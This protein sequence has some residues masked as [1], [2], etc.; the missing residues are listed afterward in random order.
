MPINLI[1]WTALLGAAAIAIGAFGAHG[2]KQLLPETSLS[3]F[4]TGVKY[5]MYHVLALLGT[6]CLYQFRPDPWLLYACRLF[7][8]GIFLFSGSLYLITLLKWNPVIGV[9][10]LGLVTPVGGVFFIA[11]WLCIW[12]GAMARK[13]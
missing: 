11:G 3:A 7:I 13:T 1:R 10:G 12:K 9:S 2:L 5:H 4:E 6:L 8:T